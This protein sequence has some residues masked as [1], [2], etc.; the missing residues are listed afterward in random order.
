MLLSL[1]LRVHQLKEK[2][3]QLEMSLVKKKRSENSYD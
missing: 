1:D 2:I 3:A